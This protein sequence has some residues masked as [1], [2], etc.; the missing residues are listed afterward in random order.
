MII[1]NNSNNNKSNRND[2]K[3]DS[4]WL[5]Y[6]NAD[7]DNTNDNAVENTDNNIDGNM[8]DNTGN[9]SDD[10]NI[11]TNH[12]NNDKN[13]ESYYLDKA[14]SLS[15]NDLFSDIYIS[16]KTKIGYLDQV[17][18][19]YEVFWKIKLLNYHELNEGFVK[20]QIKMSFY[21]KEEVE[22][23]N[24]KLKNYNYY[25]S[26]QLIDIDNPN[27]RIKFKNIKIVTIGLSKKDLLNT[28][29]KSCKSAFYNCFVLTLR[30]FHDN[31]YKEIHIKIFN[32][33]KFEVPGV[34]CDDYFVFI[35]NKFITLFKPFLD[36]NVDNNTIAF[37][38]RHVETVLI[39]SNFYCKFCI[40][41]DKLFNIL[42]HKYN[43]NSCFDPC[44]Y[45]GIQCEFHYNLNSDKKLGY[46]D[47]KIDK[48]VKIS[49]MIFRT[50]SILIVGKGDDC[51][52]CYIYEFIKNL[53][54]IEQ[55]NIVEKYLDNYY[56]YKDNKI[57][58]KKKIKKIISV[59]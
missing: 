23:C 24:N 55:A 48:F 42:R 16:T 1:N 26:K 8:Y 10:N 11:K 18:N 7:D 58:K 34:P 22:E 53:L 43:I 54:Y 51:I 35:M 13:I 15:K 12:E 33:G 3:I 19:I 29:K 20:K 31:K 9:I 44:S 14:N 30:L 21:N 6:L 36:N 25:N 2:D 46:I 41:R 17:I 37:N 47:N 59:S 28:K 32:T 27:G 39:N 49:F 40:N 4:D 56:N 50:G 57:K 45:P 5:T 38:P 52:I